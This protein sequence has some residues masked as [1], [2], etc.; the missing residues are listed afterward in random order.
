MKTLLS[1][2]ALATAAVASPH[3]S[4]ELAGSFVLHEYWTC[5]ADRMEA[6]QHTAKDTW[7][8]IFDSLV[9]DDLLIG[10]GNLVPS[11]AAYYESADATGSQSTPDHDWFSWFE[12]TSSSANDAMWEEFAKRLREEHPSDPR[13][14]VYC[15]SLTTVSYGG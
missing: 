2:V 13:P 10:W 9:A 1:R 6:L 8:P 14:W 15:D 12:T 11:G 4:A 3:A 7:A 5:G